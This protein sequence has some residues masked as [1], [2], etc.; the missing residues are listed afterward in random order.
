MVNVIEVLAAIICAVF[1]IE[2]H[3]IHRV[4]M[5]H[6]PSTK[7]T[8]LKAICPPDGQVCPRLLRSDEI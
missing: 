5:A 3:P 4:A 1:I 8:K 2:G 7:L 6:G